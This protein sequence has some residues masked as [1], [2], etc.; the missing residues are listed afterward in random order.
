MEKILEKREFLLENERKQHRQIAANEEV[1]EIKAKSKQRMSK[2]NT[3]FTKELRN[4]LGNSFTVEF[5][6]ELP[7]VWFRNG[8]TSRPI[9]TENFT[10]MT[11]L[12]EQDRLDEICNELKDLQW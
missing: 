8:D 7:Q 4:R 10:T 2:V 6:I 11:E 3:H 12:D 5:D 1:L 9:E